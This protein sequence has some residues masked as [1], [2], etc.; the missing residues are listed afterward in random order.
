MF[1]RLHVPRRVLL[2]SALGLAL[3]AAAF[4]Q[5]PTADLVGKQLQ[6]VFKRPIEVKKVSPAPVKGLCEVQV[7]FQGRPNILYTDTT[8][9][10][11]VTGHLIEAASARDLTEETISA[12]SSLS[13][14]DMK[15]VDALVA[16]TRRHQG[17]DG[18][19]RHRPALTV[20]QEGRC[21]P[22]GAGGQ[23]RDPGQGADVPAADAQGRA[24]AVRGRGLRQE[25]LRRSRERLQVRQ[26]VRRGRQAGRR[27]RSPCS[28]ARGS[29]ARR[30]TSSPTGGSSP[31]CSSRTRCASGSASR[32]RR[33]TPTAA[34]ETAPAKKYRATRAWRAAPRRP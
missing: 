33:R 27:D 5:C 4:A 22:Q 24:R 20:L 32:C 9:A 31:A 25:G 34:Q 14:E 3:P 30:R 2:A 10:Y 29:P 1:A 12:L 6:E 21:G 26:P 18:L 8:G 11:F 19:L 28:R 17:P 15:K 23:G 13:A 16:M 7:S